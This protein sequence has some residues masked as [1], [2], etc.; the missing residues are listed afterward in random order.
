MRLSERRGRRRVKGCSEFV[1]LDFTSVPAQGKKRRGEATHLPRHTSSKLYLPFTL[2]PLPNSSGLDRLGE[3]EHDGGGKLV[4]GG[5]TA[6]E[7]GR[8]EDVDCG[9]GGRC[10][11]SEDIRE[12]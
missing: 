1:L 3:V 7:G 4:G 8:F 5:T 12:E 9:K 10:R 2:V 11:R 6:R